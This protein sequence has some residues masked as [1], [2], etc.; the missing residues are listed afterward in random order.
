MSVAYSTCRIQFIPHDTDD[1]ECTYS[2]RS[3]VQLLQNDI[4]DYSLRA[5]DVENN[6]AV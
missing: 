1:P 6:N 2:E 3:V 5:T 4:T